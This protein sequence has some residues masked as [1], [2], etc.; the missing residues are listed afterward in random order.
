LDGPCTSEP[1]SLSD[2]GSY[3]LNYSAESKHS[4]ATAH[5]NLP[6]LL[7]SPLVVE[8]SADGQVVGH[9]RLDLLPVA[10]L[11]SA[12]IQARLNLIQSQEEWPLAPNANITVAVTCTRD[13]PE[14]SAGPAGHQQM[15]S[16]GAAREP[17]IPFHFVDA[18]TVTESSVLTVAPGAVTDLPSGFLSATAAAPSGLGVRLALVWRSV[19]SWTGVTS[20]LGVCSGA[21]VTW[22]TGW[23]TFVNPTDLAALK[24]AINDGSDVYLEVARLVRCHCPCMTRMRFISETARKTSIEG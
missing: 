23:R 17:F 22:Q 24:D 19:S 5:Q 20:S 8:V 7:N 10:S 16:D 9:A 6:K 3:Q 21:Q 1:C 11:A 18:A 14:E 15:P 2:V 13:A 4:L 12:S